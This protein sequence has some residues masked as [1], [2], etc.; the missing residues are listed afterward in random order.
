[1]ALSGIEQIRRGF[2]KRDVIGWVGTH[3]HAPD[4][5]QIYIPSYVFA[6]AIDPPAG[7]REIRLPNDERIRIMAMT[8]VREPYRVRA[9]GVLYS[10]G[11]AEPTS[12]PAARPRAS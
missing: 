3:R 7:A 10:P 11:L 8:A 2:V 4:S 12:A 1:G 5:D 9:A 6:Y